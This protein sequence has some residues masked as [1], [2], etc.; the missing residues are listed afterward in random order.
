MSDTGRQSLTDKAGA[1]LKPDSEKSY[2]EQAK[3]TISGKTDS[4][5]STAQPQSQ[6]SYTQEIGD[7]FSGNKND[8]QESLTDKAKNA[9]GAN[10]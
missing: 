2:L 3:D 1:A 7:A 9:F 8:N 10:Q 4:A 5:A 6:K